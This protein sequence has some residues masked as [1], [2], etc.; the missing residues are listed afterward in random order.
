MSWKVGK[1]V[2]SLI[3]LTEGLRPRPSWH[4]S[5]AQQKKSVDSI[6]V[7][8][9]PYTDGLCL[10]IRTQMSNGTGPPKLCPPSPVRSAVNGLFD[11]LGK[12]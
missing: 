6:G 4:A 3:S 9:G 2:L 8:E 10:S 7:T 12:R 5:S 1:S 11:F